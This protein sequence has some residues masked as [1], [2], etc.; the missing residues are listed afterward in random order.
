MRKQEIKDLRVRTIQ[1]LKDLASIAPPNMIA[2]TIMNLYNAELAKW[3]RKD[4]E[5][6]C[7]IEHYV[8][9]ES[10][11]GR[12]DF[13]RKVIQLGYT[14]KRFILDY[15]Y[16]DRALEEP[17]FTIAVS[18]VHAVDI[19]SLEEIVFELSDSARPHGGT[20][21]S[22]AERY[23]KEVSAVS[24]NFDGRDRHVNQHWVYFREEQQIEKFK[25]QIQLNGYWIE[26]V[27]TLSGWQYK[28]VLYFS[29]TSL[30]D[31]TN[32]DAEQI[33]IAEIS[34]RFDGVYFWRLNG[35]ENP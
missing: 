26:K 6:P 1:A 31:G 3:R 35:E 13:L 5:I 11:E 23:P 8:Q 22:W 30:A 33:K 4:A 9:F 27:E 7:E 2:L 18:K 10:R 19:E 15:G 20:Y 21:I 28:Q 34:E 14:V 16:G 24:A 25:E 32:A 29:G 17:D 12:R